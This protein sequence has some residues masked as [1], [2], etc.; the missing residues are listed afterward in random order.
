MNLEAFDTK[1]DLV[2]ATKITLSFA[3]VDLLESFGLALDREFTEEENKRINRWL[4]D[5]I[6]HIM[7]NFYEE[8]NKNG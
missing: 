4:N 5:Q 1:V 2:T 6:P 7:R 8:K 3:A